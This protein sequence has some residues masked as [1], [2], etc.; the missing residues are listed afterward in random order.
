MP[1]AEVR[2]IRNLKF[3]IRTFPPI[4]AR[5]SLALP[6]P[7][8]D[9]DPVENICGTCRNPIHMMSL[10][11]AAAGVRSPYW[12]FVILVVA[13]TFI[14]IAI[15]RLRLHAF[16]AL[17][18]AAFLVGFLTQ[19]FKESLIEKL[20]AAMREDARANSWVAAV[21]LTAIEFG[22]AAGGIAISIGLASI[23]GLCLMES[24]AADKVV[25][26]FLALFGERR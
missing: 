10:F 5:R 20:P 4:W 11:A 25:R 26:R 23:I 7:P 24:G 22:T 14:I 17:I 9:L 12:P 16:I 3:G 21:E 13:I 2:T 19:G 15:T 1:N 18:F 6:S 8:T